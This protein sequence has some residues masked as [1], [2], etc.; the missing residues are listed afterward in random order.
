MKPEEEHIAIANERYVVGATVP[1]L[2][3]APDAVDQVGT[4][5][6]LELADGHFLITAMH[7]FDNRASPR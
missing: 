3:D 2:Y 7:T 6:L 4:G 1:I 5:T